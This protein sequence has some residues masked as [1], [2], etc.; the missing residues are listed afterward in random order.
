[1][2]NVLQRRSPFQRMKPCFSKINKWPIAAF[3]GMLTCAGASHGV[4][5]GLAEQSE[6]W[7][8]T[9][10]SVV[11]LL[12][13][14]RKDIAA[15]ARELDR[16]TPVSGPEAMRKLNVLLRAG[17]WSEAMKAVDQLHAV[18]PE[19]ANDPI[20]SI[21][22]TACDGFEAWEVARQLAEVFADNIQELPLES[23]LL[24]HFTAA[25]WS[26]DAIDEWLAAR[27]AGREGFWIKERLRFNSSHGRADKLIEKLSAEVRANPENINAAIQFLDA[28]LYSSSGPEKRW[29]LSWIA[30]TIH[31]TRAT[32]AQEIARRLQRLREWAS[33]AT[34]FRAALAIPLSAEEVHKLGSM[35]QAVLPRETIAARFIVEAREG[36]SECLLILGDKAEAQRLMEEAVVLRR[37]RDLGDNMQFAG[38]TQAATGARVIESAILEEQKKSEKDPEYWLERA[39]YYRGR[40]EAAAE[41]EAYRKALA[42]TEP[43]PRPEHPGKGFADL[44]STVISNLDR[45]LTQ[46]QREDEALV[47]LLKELQDS[48]AQSVS[49]ER[50]AYLI[51]F[52]HRERIAPDEDTYWRWLSNRPVWDHT[53]ER[54]LWEL[55][56]RVDPPKLDAYLTRA[57][58]LSDSAH[59]SRNRALGWVMN[60]MNFAARSIPLLQDAVTRLADKEQR[61]SAQ[62]TLFESYLGIGDWQHAEALFPETSRRLTGHEI[63]S[64]QG[65][66]AVAA[67]R[68][69]AKTDALRIW[70]SATNV[71]PCF[72]GSLDDLAAADLTTELRAFYVEFSKRLPS[73]VVPARA[74]KILSA[75]EAR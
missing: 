13:R 3:V 58:K 64:W 9:D 71:N 47:L 12:L 7:S 46:H 65:R 17:L 67:A 35:S 8:R 5:A 44:R 19:L 36:L 42:L 63:P 25:G 75:G 15:M 1:L 16:S 33:A 62:F 18:C 50:A 40:E 32:D 74:L 68:A 52:E 59:P 6:W 54:L 61:D 51:A 2:L 73:S 48:P 56:R 29:E 39:A 31:P 22:Y 41:E 38:R 43:K 26:V 28:V 14:E 24:T 72:I 55:L 23:R 4:E 69:G 21:F 27:P 10:Q 30:D 11:D 34:F 57:E 66:I 53:E 60:R 70:K 37:E 45:F 49:V 20:Y